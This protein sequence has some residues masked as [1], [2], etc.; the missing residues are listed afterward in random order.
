MR[1]DFKGGGSFRVETV[2]KDDKVCLEIEQK[3]DGQQICL[4]VEEVEAIN[5]I[6]EEL[7][8]AKQKMWKK[9]NVRKNRAV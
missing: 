4:T 6:I 1:M 9:N 7:T 3:C 2:V 5:A 8:W